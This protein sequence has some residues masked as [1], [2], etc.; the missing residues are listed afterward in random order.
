MRA[1]ARATYRVQMRA[2]FDFA[3]AAE[4]VPYL[5]QLGVSHLYCSPYMQAAPHSTHGYDVVDPTKVSSELGGERGLRVLDRALREARM[6]QLLD[7]VPNHMCVADRGNRWWWDVLRTGRQSPYAAMFDIDWDAP[8]LRGRVLLPVLRDP[9]TD[10][11]ERAALQV[12]D[13]ND[14]FELYYCG[15]R[16]PLAVGSAMT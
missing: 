12:V 8:A 1:Q 16:F 13:G 15:T 5:H 9:L 4:I 14:G 2:E 3:A 7:I 10:V 11:L 6:G